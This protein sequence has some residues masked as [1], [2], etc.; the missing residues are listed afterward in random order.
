MFTFP[1]AENNFIMTKE[2]TKVVSWIF[3]KSDWA[4]LE[5]DKMSIESIEI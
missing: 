4:S 1:A 3:F 5:D 2:M